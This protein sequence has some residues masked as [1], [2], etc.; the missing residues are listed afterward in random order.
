M[1]YSYSAVAAE[2]VWFHGLAVMNGLFILVLE[3][4]NPGCATFSQEETLNLG[5]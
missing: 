5:R 1:N 2:Y 4:S 3:S